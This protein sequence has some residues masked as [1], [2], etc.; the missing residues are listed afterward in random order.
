[1]SVDHRLLDLIACPQ[2]KGPLFPCAQREA[3]CCERCHLKFPIID[4]IP[5]LL[6]DEAEHYE[7][8]MP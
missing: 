2:C 5:V 8:K 7:G 1:M 6:L 4:D 3:L